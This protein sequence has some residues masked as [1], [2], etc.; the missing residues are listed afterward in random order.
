MW[1]VQYQL[2]LDT[3]CTTNESKYNIRYVLLVVYMCHTY[4][5][6]TNQNKLVNAMLCLANLFWKVSWDTRLWRKSVCN[7]KSSLSQVV[8][9]R[10]VGTPPL[11]TK[12]VW[13]KKWSLSQAVSWRRLRCVLSCFKNN[14]M[15]VQQMIC[16]FLQSI[17]VT[18]ILH[19]LKKVSLGPLWVTKIFTTSRRSI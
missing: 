10:S 15:D 2:C 12:N 11:V 16:F 14:E 5:L 4:E 1:P 8:S 6:P 17:S 7:E 3:K 13:N 19:F 9:R 18:W